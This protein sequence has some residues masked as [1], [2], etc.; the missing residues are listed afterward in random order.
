MKFKLALAALLLSA[1]H[2]AA[3]KSTF[4]L[5]ISGQAIEFRRAIEISDL[6]DGKT[7]HAIAF[8]DKAGNAYALDLK[9]KALPSNRSFPGNLDITLKDGK[10]T[11]LGYLFL[12]INGVK[13]LK[14]MGTFG[15]VVDVAG[16]PVDVRFT[17]P[18]AETAAQAGKLDLAQLD[19]ERLI[20][21][22]LVPKFDFQMIRPMVMPT[23]KP[24]LREQTYSLDQHPYEVGYALVDL[25]KGSVEV[26]ANLARKVDGKTHL[27]NRVYFHADRIETVRE[28][29]YAAKHFDATD[30]TFKLVYYPAM[31]QTTPA[32]K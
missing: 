5:S 2:A 7:E 25:G 30:G 29:M 15:L 24:G 23:V 32:A 1:T 6:A 14:Q 18:G 3:E 16:E 12:A 17:A 19:G 26:Q 31:G 21:D 11:K 10:G 27:L 20:L 22:I 9:Y 4:D 28:A 8:T 13:F